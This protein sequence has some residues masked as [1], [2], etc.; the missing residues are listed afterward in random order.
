MKLLSDQEREDFEYVK[1]RIGELKEARKEEQFGVELEKIWLAADEDYTPHRLLDHSK[2]T[3]IEDEDKG[4]RGVSSIV[5]LGSSNWQSDISQPN[6][7]I[8]IQVALAILVDQNPKGVFTAATKKYVATTEL[9][10]QLYQRSWDY[11]KSKSQLKLFVFNLAKYGWACARTYPLKITRT[12]KNLTKY[13][14]D[15]PSKSTYEEKEVTEYNDVM[16]E[17]LD[18]WNVWID[19][20]AKPNNSRSVKDWAWRKVC[21]LDAAREEFGSWPNF[22]YVKPGGIVTDKIEETDKISKKFKTKDLVEIYGFES[23]AKDMFYVVIGD[24]PVI[25]S[26]LPISDSKGNKKLSLWQTYWNLRHAESA[27]GIG[28]YE[29][30]RMNQAMLD[31]INN[32]SIDQLTLSIYKMFFYQGTNQLTE[33]GDIKLSPGVG[34]QTLDPKNINFLEIPGPGQES[35]NWRQMIRQDLDEDSGITDPLLGNVTGKTAFEIAQA[36]EAALKRLK[37]PLE[38]ITDA[39][40]TEAYITISLMQLIY[41]TPEVYEISNPDLIDAYLKEIQGDQQLFDRSKTGTFQAKVYPEFPI[42][43][44]ADEK[45][46]LIETNQTEFF[47]IKPDSLQWE[48]IVNVESQSVLSPSKQ[49]DK[50]LDLE[51]YNMLIPLLMQPPEIYSKVAKSIV[52]L[53]DKDPKDI[54]P[55][56]WL[57]DPQQMEAQQQAQQQQSQPLIVQPGQ[58]AP[59][60]PQGQAPQQA[61]QGQAPQAPTLV[62]STQPPQNPSS[63]V[64]KISQ[65]ISQPF[66]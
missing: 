24:V 14:E 54:L 20:M 8:K 51:M 10:K 39:L 52:K 11:A 56:A 33:T 45:G 9:I 2:K 29:A 59:Q 46:N 32:M 63:L 36:K 61:P 42:N 34:K 15:D 28:I 53:Y 17:N 48:G 25:M 65:R 60:G 18:P 31:R 3:L 6:P 35:V 43:L 1:R 55:A 64:G 19:E 58:P 16:R 7:F 5:K 26:P 49:V 13:N 30:I 23:V 50:A 41:S 21:T 57:V 62:P 40:D 4:W 12:V 27:Y 44:S 66:Q 22:Q 47:R 37:T 38:N